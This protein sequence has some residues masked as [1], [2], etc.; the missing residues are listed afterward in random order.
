MGK[1]LIIKGA[2]FAI[3]AIEKIT[4]TT[5]Y[6]TVMYNLYHCSA[7]NTASIL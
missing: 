1:R 3:N 5:N 2:S 7:S 6:Y 4:P